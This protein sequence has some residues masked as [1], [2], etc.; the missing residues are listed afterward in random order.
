ML[1]ALQICVRHGCH[2]HGCHT[3]GACCYLQ[4]VDAQIM[5]SM[6][7]QNPTSGSSGGA[8]GWTEPSGGP[9]PFAGDTTIEQSVRI[10]TKEGKTMGLFAAGTLAGVLLTVAIFSAA[11]GGD[12]STPTVSSS[13]SPL[14]PPPPPP[15]PK[16]QVSSSIR[17]SE[18]SSQQFQAMHS[19]K[20]KLSEFKASFRQQIANQIG[21]KPSDVVVDGIQTG[22]NTVTFH[23]NVPTGPP[24]PPSP[25]TGPPPPPAKTP[26]PSPSPP[27]PPGTTLGPPPPSP[28]IGTATGSSPPPPARSKGPP[29][30][31]TPT[32]PRTKSPPS[33]PAPAKAHNGK[34][35]T[36]KMQDLYKMLHDMSKKDTTIKVK[37]MSAST[38]TVSKPVTK[39]EP[40]YCVSAGTSHL[41][42][43]YQ[44]AIY[45]LGA[46]LGRKRI[47]TYVA[48]PT[49]ST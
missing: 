44:I 2:T 33:P 31:P 34:Q 10:N 3:H 8:G 26:P 18:N 11:T 37:G 41:P 28:P 48:H 47:Q 25:A 46:V 9:P 49:V 1:F 20:T 38:S 40:W 39:S 13:H 22:S 35:P 16:H 23:I 42:R 7:T 15:P 4:R 30:P 19:N 32:P 12:S 14:P 6:Y 17:F 45:N 27:P 36:S 29:P 21:V 5:A 43:V 24:P